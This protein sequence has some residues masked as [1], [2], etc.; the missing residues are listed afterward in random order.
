[1]ISVSH[2]VDKDLYYGASVHFL[3]D[4]FPCAANVWRENQPK[5]GHVE[6]FSI[7]IIAIGAIS[8]W[9]CATVLVCLKSCNGTPDEQIN[10]F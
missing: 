1:M 6:L 5:I 2:M 9:L 10:L 8:S 4:S 7:K 3:R